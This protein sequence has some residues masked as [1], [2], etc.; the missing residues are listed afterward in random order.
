MPLQSIQLCHIDRVSLDRARDDTPAWDVTVH[1][2]D[3]QQHAT[4]RCTT[5]ADGIALRNAIRQHA[6]KLRRVAD[7]SR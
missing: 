4:F 1:S 7:Y 2:D 5:E 3:Q 6:D